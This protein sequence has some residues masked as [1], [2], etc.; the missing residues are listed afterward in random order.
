MGGKKKVFRRSCHI[1][2]LLDLAHEFKFL[3]RDAC[4]DG[5]V[6]SMCASEV[7]GVDVKSV[8]VRMW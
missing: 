2:F 5:E 8:A 7:L 6:S 1:F 3:L 4:H